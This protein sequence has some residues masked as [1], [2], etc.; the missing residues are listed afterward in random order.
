MVLVKTYTLAVSEKP[1]QNLYEW[2]EYKK[3]N[4]IRGRGTKIPPMIQIS[5][6]KTVYDLFCKVFDEWIA[7]WREAF[8]G[9][10]EEEDEHAWTVVIYP[11]RDLAYRFDSNPAGIKPIKWMA[12]AYSVGT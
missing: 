7:K 5:G 2:K 8:Q 12:P 3:L 1:A 4:N 10:D 6:S 11:P 9:F